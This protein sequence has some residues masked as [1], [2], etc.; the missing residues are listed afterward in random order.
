MFPHQSEELL[1]LMETLT[2]LAG[3]VERSAEANVGARTVQEQNAGPAEGS[4]DAPT[5]QDAQRVETFIKEVA[6]LDQALCRLRAS[7]QKVK[8]LLAIS[9]TGITGLLRLVPEPRGA[10]GHH[11]AAL[12]HRVSQICRIAK[13]KFNALKEAY[14][15]LRAAEVNMLTVAEKVTDDGRAVSGA[16]GSQEVTVEEDIMTL[17]QKTIVGILGVLA[18]SGDLSQ[19]GEQFAVPAE[20]FLARLRRR[21]QH[22][23]TAVAN[24]DAPTGEE[25]HQETAVPSVVPPTGQ[26]AQRVETF[27]NEVAALDQALCQLRASQKKVKR[28]LA[29]SQAGITGL[30]QPVPQP[31]GAV[32]RH[33][34]VLPH[35]R[36]HQYRVV[37]AKFD[38]LKEAYNQLKAAEASTLTL[39]DKVAEDGR[40]V[41]GAWGSQ[42]VTADEDSMALVKKTLVGVLLVLASSGDISQAVEEFAVTAEAFLARRRRQRITKSVEMD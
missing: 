7:Q 27:I 18:N 42:E 21:K 31:R 2:F 3:H 22:K 29:I 34:A 6:A 14:Y 25:Q 40:A 37:K 12:P 1:T 30:L 32:G 10:V 24:V 38:A 26:C 39:A 28:L 41:S 17:I 33:V 11:S 4:A 13:A 15:L 35:R 36:S 23:Q 19:A 5:R 8:R 9:Q 20:A 16:L